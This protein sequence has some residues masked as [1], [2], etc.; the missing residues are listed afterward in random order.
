VPGNLS[1]DVLQA[2][3]D[4]IQAE[5]QLRA[6]QA[7]IGAAK[8]A[9]YPRITLSTS[10][11]LVSDTLSGL[12]NG[13]TFAWT[14]G[15]Q[16]AMALFDSGR[17][18]ASVRVA[19]LSRDVAIAQYQKT[20]QTAFKEAADALVAQAGWRDQSQAQRVQLA[21]ERERHRLTRLKFEAGA[22]SQ[23]DWLDA[24]RSLASA[25]QAL[26]QV[27]LAEW[28]NRVALYKALG[29]ETATR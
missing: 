26:V 29:G 27:R 23:L 4:V 14:L 6:A 7:N 11:G 21:A 15:G 20:A 24:E 1:S 3:P 2:R 25:E 8:A 17:N 10:A 12:L 9:V 18:Q 22:I 16:A 13:G 5:Q 28:L 19:E